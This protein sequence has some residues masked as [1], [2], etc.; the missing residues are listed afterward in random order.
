M[1]D[2]RREGAGPTQRESRKAG[3]EES[4]TTDELLRLELTHPDGLSAQAIVEMLAE[5]GVTLAEA[6]FRKYVQLGLL[7]RSRRVGRKGKHRGSHG[8]YP[9]SVVARIVAIRQLM[10]GGLTLEEIQRSSVALAND[11]ESV[12]GSSDAFLDKL[13]REATARTPQRAALVRRRIAQLRSQAEAL[14]FKLEEAAEELC[15]AT[16]RVHVDGRTREMTE[17]TVRTNAGRRSAKV[18]VAG[19]VGRKNGGADP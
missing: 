2:D 1:C 16:A 5:R 10:E 4:F 13:E 19:R 17:Q 14:V 12:R 7:P 11:I 18:V 3:V 6:T 9:A 15:P 8:L